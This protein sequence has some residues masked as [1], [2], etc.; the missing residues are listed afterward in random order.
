M[1][2][3]FSNK[4]TGNC[5]QDVRTHLRRKKGA[6]HSAPKT[7]RVRHYVRRCPR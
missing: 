3:S 4:T 1:K 7:V 6:P 5:T 2:Q